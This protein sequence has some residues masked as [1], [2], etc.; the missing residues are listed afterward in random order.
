MPTQVSGVLTTYN[1]P[2]Y[3]GQLHM[4]SPTDTP[5]YS[6]IAGLKGIKIINSNYWEWQTESLIAAGQNAAL[7]AAAAPTAVVNK[8]DNVHNVLQIIHKSV[9][10]GYSKKAG[11]NQF[12]GLNIN[13]T[14]IV[15]D[16]VSHQLGNKLLEFGRDIEYSFINGVLVEPTDNTTARKTRGLLEAITTNVIANS[17]ATAL[18]KA[19]VNTLLQTIWDNGGISQADTATILVPSALKVA[20]SDLF[21]SNKFQSPDRNVAGVNLETIVTDFGTLNVMLSRYMPA[22]TIAVCSLEQCMPVMRNVDGKG[23]I[24]SEKLALTGAS[25]KYQLYGEVGFEWGN[26]LAH[27]KITGVTA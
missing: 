22:D 5:L 19:M 15:V 17:P 20:L 1:Y 9:E 18:T 11:F 10:V 12:A 26:Q 24:F 21:F 7:E 14:P 6:S 23:V 25:E 4:I 8:R 2:N 13:D 16:E 27:G 3:H